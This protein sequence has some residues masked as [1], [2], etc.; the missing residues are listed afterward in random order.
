MVDQMN[1]QPPKLGN[2]AEPFEGGVISEVVLNDV[3]NR[4][5]VVVRDAMEA[6]GLGRV[7]AQN[8]AQ[9]WDFVRKRY[10]DEVFTVRLTGSPDSIGTFQNLLDEANNYKDTLTGLPSYEMQDKLVERINQAAS[11]IKDGNFI[12]TPASKSSTT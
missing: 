2:A 10:V 4:K 1:E 6:A 5:F 8:I 11:Q 3:H 7:Q 12:L 9:K